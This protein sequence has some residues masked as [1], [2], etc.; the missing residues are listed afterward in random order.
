ME[1]RYKLV[2]NISALDGVYPTGIIRRRLGMKRSLTALFCSY[3][4]I[5]AALAD[6]GVIDKTEP[7]LERGAE[8]T[9]HGIK[10]GV[11]ATGRGIKRG[12]E[13]AGHGIEVGLSAAARGIRRGAEAT[14]HA[15]Q[16]AAEKV[17]PSSGA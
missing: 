7:A 12:A 16:K 11:E 17:S 3:F 10:R 15:L 9:A 2:Q 4:L 6:Q 13:A 14:G 1:N 8:A 5:G